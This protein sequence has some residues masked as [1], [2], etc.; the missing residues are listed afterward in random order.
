MKSGSQGLKLIGSSGLF[1]IMVTSFGLSREEVA[2]LRG[3]LSSQRYFVALTEEVSAR[4]GAGSLLNG[5]YD[6][7]VDQGSQ[8]VRSLRD[9][10]TGTTCKFRRSAAP[11]SGKRPRRGFRHLGRTESRLRNILF[12][13]PRLFDSGGRIDLIRHFVSDVWH[14]KN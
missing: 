8:N 13:R 9:R 7:W 1:K 5:R 2:V 11:N 14:G 4:Q 6:G 12:V 3:E 10:L